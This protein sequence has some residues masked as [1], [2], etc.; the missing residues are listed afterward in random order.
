MTTYSVAGIGLVT[1]LLLPELL[2]EPPGPDATTWTI[3]AAESLS[4]PGPHDVL[5]E[6]HQTDGR[7]WSRVL[8]APDGTYVLDFPDL[9][10]F[11]IDP[12]RRVVELVGQPGLAD[13]TRAHLVIDQLVPHLVSLGGHLVLH[14]SAVAIRGR[15]IAILGTS[16]AGKSSL[17]A[18]FVQRGHRLLADD[19]LRLRE[20]AGTYVATAAYP[21]LRL[22]DDSATHFGGDADALSPVADFTAKRRLPVEATEP[23][24]VPLGAVLALGYAPEPGAPDCALELIEGRDAFMVLYRQAFRVER[25]GRAVQ[26]ADL[27]RFVRLAEAVPV[28]LMEHR[29]TYDALPNVLDTIERVL[30]Q[31]GVTADEPS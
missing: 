20:D 21:G 3:V 7:L 19:Y 22:W 1:D 14:S 27:D 29:R 6:S 2:A 9:V 8:G 4:S 12:T 16:G 13:S 17:A 28:L 11:G 18:A 31:M 24:P 23:A 10:G 5:S 25:A 15:A 30:D 26:E